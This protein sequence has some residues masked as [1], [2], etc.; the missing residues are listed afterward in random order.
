MATVL[1]VL[2]SPGLLSPHFE[3]VIRSFLMNI[4]TGD[5]CDTS[6]LVMIRTATASTALVQHDSGLDG[7]SGQMLILNSTHTLRV[8]KCGWHE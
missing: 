6:K 4:Y 5:V 1:L 2:A 8:H 3:M 7:S